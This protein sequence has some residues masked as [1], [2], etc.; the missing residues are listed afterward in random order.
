MIRIK[1]IDATGR[2]TKSI[3]LEPW[4]SDEDVKAA[5]AA[6]LEWFKADAAAALPELA[7]RSSRLKGRLTEITTAA[8]GR[9]FDEAEQKL[10]DSLK[11]QIENTDR[12]WDRAKEVTK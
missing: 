5:R 9:D 6:I 3:D 7:A 10:A 8:K 12:K 11:A 2:I 1:H 4:A